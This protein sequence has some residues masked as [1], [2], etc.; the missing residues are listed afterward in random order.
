MKDYLDKVKPYLRDV[1]I[2]HQKSDTWKIQLTNA[3]NF[4]SLKDVDGESVMQSKNNN[5]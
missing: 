5:I 2:S 3:I 4:I 1:I